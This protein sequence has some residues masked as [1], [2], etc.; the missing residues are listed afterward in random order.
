MTTVGTAT[1]AADGSFSFGA[2][3]LAPGANEFDLTAVDAAGNSATRSYSF[4]RDSAAPSLAAALQNDTGISAA[5]GLTR[6][7][8]IA[9]SAS[10]NLGLTA[11]G[12][13]LDPGTTPVFS[14]V[15]SGVQADGSFMLTS[16]QLAT[17]AG[18]TLA[19]GSHT[20]RLR[21]SDA[22]GNT[23]T[24]DLTFTLDRAAP[25]IASLALAA[26]SDS[27]TVGDQLTNAAAVTLNGS[28]EAAARLTLMRG[29]A[30]PSA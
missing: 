19:D 23:T 4:R 5:D 9:G 27:G 2:V 24:R 1:A 7:A 3:T 17:L 8:T 30:T 11:L 10:D 6:D 13:A 18:G 16:A 15:M 26:A 14:D 25:A 29:A 22:A 12:A 20:L 21:A 28:A